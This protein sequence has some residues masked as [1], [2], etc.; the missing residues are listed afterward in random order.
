MRS[1]K[2]I[3]N[4]GI[5]D[6]DYVTQRN[7]DGVRVICPYYARWK[8][9]LRR[10]YSPEMM[11]GNPTYIHCTVCNEWLTFSNF[12]TWM[13]NQDWHGKHLD[14]DILI[15]GSTEYSPTNCR[16]ITV[17]T[18]ILLCHSMRRKNGLPIG[19]SKGHSGYL[20]QASIGEQGVNR[21]L[22]LHNDLMLAHR[23]WQFA[24]M[25]NIAMIAGK[26]EDS[27]IKNALMMRVEIISNHLRMG[28]ETKSIH[29]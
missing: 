20:Y 25:K 15:M 11:V 26:Q 14:K 5:N 6:A 16:F 24:K 27:D 12:R 1:R 22:G 28:I 10:C 29:H 2:K 8:Q 17:E 13:I 18:N 23:Q 3:Y 4:I 7:V 21:S 19:V 9:M